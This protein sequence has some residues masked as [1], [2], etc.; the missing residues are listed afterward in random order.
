MLHL[1]EATC[2]IKINSLKGFT[3]VEVLVSLFII[4]LFTLGY[5]KAMTLTLSAKQQAA[6]H[7][8]WMMHSKNQMDYYLAGEKSVA[9]VTVTP[10]N[11]EQTLHRIYVKSPCKDMESLSILIR[12][13]YT[14]EKPWDHISYYRIED[15]VSDDG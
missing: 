14:K 1:R 9:D 10:L 6:M 11:P 15:W 7:H 2:V 3:L 13:T 8:Q 12:V 4:S 5:S